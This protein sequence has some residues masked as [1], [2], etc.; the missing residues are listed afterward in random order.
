MNPKQ[1]EKY[2]ER[3]KKLLDTARQ[4][5]SGME[6]PLGHAL[7]AAVLGKSTSGQVTAQYRGEVHGEKDP[8]VVAHRRIVGEGMG[9]KFNPMLRAISLRN[10]AN[11]LGDESN[12]NID[13]ISST[14]AAASAAE[15]AARGGI[16]GRALSNLLG[17]IRTSTVPTQSYPP[18][19]V[20]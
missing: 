15:G 13:R 10:R 5:K 8:F 18:K 20:P 17:T 9:F 16:R 19:I 2:R 7:D 1:I 6:T 4:R 11:R 14:S 3:I 12:P